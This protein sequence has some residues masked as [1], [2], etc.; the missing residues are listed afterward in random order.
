MLEK[1]T[2]ARQED[3]TVPDKE[4]H[5]GTLNSID[6]KDI[7]VLLGDND[8]KHWPK[9]IAEKLKADA[10]NSYEHGELSYKLAREFISR[11]EFGNLNNRQFQEEFFSGVTS[12][13]T[14]SDFKR[15]IDKVY[16]IADTI[17]TYSNRY[18]FNTPNA[19][20]AQAETETNGQEAK[21]TYEFI[22][23]TSDED[24]L[25][26]I[27]SSR[28]DL[29]KLPG[30]Q[31]GEVLNRL[32]KT[33]GLDEY[34]VFVVIGSKVSGSQFLE[35]FE[36][37]A[38]NYSHAATGQKG[39]F[40][41]YSFWEGIARTAESFGFASF[42][43]STLRMYGH[44]SVDPF[45]KIRFV[46]ELNKWL[47][48][49]KG[50]SDLIVDKLDLSNAEDYS[51]AILLDLLHK[52][53]RSDVE[54]GSAVVVDGI[55][56]R[57]EE[58]YELS[59]RNFFLQAQLENVKDKEKYAG[60]V[61]TYA[62]LYVGD[63]Q[64]IVFDPYGA[65]YLST[66]EDYELLSKLAQYTG[67]RTWGAQRIP[68]ILTPDR[69]SEE[70]S[71]DFYDSGLFEKHEDFLTA[72]GEDFIDVAQRYNF[73]LLDDRDFPVLGQSSK[74][75]SSQEI[76]DYLYMVQP[77][78]RILL[79]E[80]FGVDLSK[81]SRPEQLHFLN[82]LKR[83]KVANT[84]TMKRFISLYGVDGMRT[85]LSLERGDETLGDNIV[86]FGQ[87]D[88]IAGTVFK[89]YS[90]L[91]DRAEQAEKLVKEFSDCE[92]DVCIEQSNQV[93]DNILNRAQIDL[94]KAVRAHDPSEVVAKIEHY[95][96]EAK[97]Y[98]AL[99]QEVGTKKIE[100]T[101]PENLSEEDKTRMKNLLQANYR[102]AYPDPKDDAFK[103]AV[104]SSLN[105]SFSNPNTTYRLLRDNGKIVSYNRFD[106]IR[107]YTGKEVS[108]F[109][110]FNADPAYSGVGGVMLEETTKDQLEN[111]S[112]MMGHCD[113]SQDITKKYIE[114]G[115]VA[116]Q[117]YP[118]AG[119]PS[120]EIWRSKDSSALLESKGQPVEKLLESIGES[121][122]MIVREQSES[123]NYPE[124]QNGMGLTRYFTHEGKTYLVFEILP[125]TLRETFTPPKEEQKEVA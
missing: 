78:M 86:A 76:A 90:E 117:F 119:K 102:I 100:T 123:E 113:P 106:T 10:L 44:P 55:V 59:E 23:N 65:A 85:F 107:D 31:L 112:P 120:F 64:Y 11:D 75:S 57:L 60:G 25:D 68:E 71:F 3:E 94:E 8:P 91:L 80:S 73:H 82:Y 58:K 24:L 89:Y 28:L 18:F 77:E 125:D 62:P 1:L 70:E 2:T 83:T 79:H 84:D 61:G 98:V 47:V 38:I 21:A 74:P 108:Y 14:Y 5:P 66:K 36:H 51:N 45:L 33:A 99:L 37:V 29:S 69:K 34:H 32:F 30:D 105:K 53:S 121:E 22:T 96:A 43:E 88:E 63:E 40:K 101:S 48:G 50:Y 104:A 95:V 26:S 122:S 9:I 4:I 124:L 46:L 87:H 15:F 110:S 17:G 109:G 56:S 39:I 20:T 116:T 27:N 54:K 93:R 115:F 7:G 114:N 97:E 103:A 6:R 42:L 49:N 16:D 19:N 72:R 81:L 35:A 67:P 111:G 92:G 118:L 52:Q 12:D 13:L 41:M